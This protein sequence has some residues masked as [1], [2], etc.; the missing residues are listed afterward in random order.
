MF[1]SHRNGFFVLPVEFYMAWHSPSYLIMESVF[2]NGYTVRTPAKPSLRTTL[3]KI[4]R[5]ERI[6]AFSHV[7]FEQGVFFEDKNSLIADGDYFVSNY[8]PRYR[9]FL[10]SEIADPGVEFSK[11]VGAANSKSWEN[12][13]NYHEHRNFKDQKN[14][15]HEIS[16]LIVER[17]SNRVNDPKSILELGCGS[18][19]NLQYLHTRF[20]NAQITGIDIHEVVNDLTIARNVHGIKSDILNLDWNLL[21]KFD[22]I[23]TSGLLMHINNFAVKDLL[24][25]I[26]NNS[27]I[28]FHFEL[29]G[30]SHFWDYDRYPRSYGELAQILNLEIL[31]YSVFHNDGVYSSALTSD[32]AHVFF[33]VKGKSQ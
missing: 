28:H 23:F 27:S 4:K 5:R 7:D 24:T 33:A 21:G 3:G 18:G 26:N 6:L 8:S 29:H 12:Q 31:E 30:E 9:I 22:V 19:R 16:K 13:V 11:V 25:K 15:A 2:G 10:A 17:I 32:F 14:R 20:P 1:V